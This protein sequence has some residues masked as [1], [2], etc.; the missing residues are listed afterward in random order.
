VISGARYLLGLACLVIVAAM[1]ASS[2]DYL[3]KTQAAANFAKGA[4]LSRFFA[5]FYMVTSALTFGVQAAGSSMWLKR[6]GPGR[7]VAVLPVAVTGVSIAS[8]FAP[9][10]IALTVSRAIELLLRGSLY[11]SGYELFYT[12]M[13]AAEKRSTKSVIDIGAERLGDGLAGASIQLL[14]ALPAQMVTV[15]ILTL[16]AGLSALGIWLAM[17]L[18]KVYVKILER[19]LEHHAAVAPASAETPEDATVT[20]ALNSITSPGALSSA[21]AFPHSIAPPSSPVLKDSALRHLVELR[22]GDAARITTALS[23]MQ[24]LAPVEVPQVIE[25]L[26][27][28]DVA[29]AAYFALKK[30]A[31]AIAGQ[32]VDAM[33]NPSSTFN[34]RKRIPKVLSSCKNRVGCDGLVAHLSD[35]RFE[36]RIRCAKALEKILARA[37]ELRPD[38]AVIFEVVSKE[39]GTA[40]KFSQQSSRESG[41]TIEGALK[42]RATKT[43]EHI[44]N[45]LGLVLPRQSVRLAFRALQ[46]G[47]SEVR[48]VALEYLDSILPKSLRE[49]LTSHFEGSVPVLK[50]PAMTPE[51]IAQLV[52]SNPSMMHRL[53]HWASATGQTGDKKPGDSTKS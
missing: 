48:G 41:V 36:V 12:P 5:L 31:D 28:D 45:L 11:R 50:G 34:V 26:D 17:R 23:R 39:L 8:I 18:D 44:F 16:T 42:E 24:T 51:A 49:D 47:G 25:L 6:F 4:P 9:G 52:D 40:R 1:A 21:P 10:L 37:P 30:N 19:G 3:F 22:S 43:I 46:P 2:L 33:Q 53:E 13:P 15:T 32:L 29:Q 14:L 27:R 20:V 7:T 35:E 38:P